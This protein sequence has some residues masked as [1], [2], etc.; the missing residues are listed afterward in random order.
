[1]LVNAAGY[2]TRGSRH[3]S[4]SGFETNSNTTVPLPSQDIVISTG[5]VCNVNGSNFSTPCNVVSGGW[6]TLQ[7][8]YMTAN[9]SVISSGV[10]TPDIHVE[11]S[12][13]W[14]I[15]NSTGDTRLYTPTVLVAVENETI[16]FDTGTSGNVVFTPTYRC[17]TGRIQGCPANYTLINKTEISAC[18]PE[19]T[20]RIVSFESFPGHFENITI[21]TGSR[22]INESSVHAATNLK[23]NPNGKP[24][25]SLLSS[26]ADAGAKLAGIGVSSALAVVVI[27]LG[28]YIF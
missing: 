26:G 1:M 18:Y 27:W 28:V 9:G 23:Q 16:T 10:T 4:C 17:V 12:L 25:Y 19:L 7:N 2:A 15:W 8:V 5:V 13:G 14:T 3:P 22:S 21:A 6:P 20:D 11:D 24:P